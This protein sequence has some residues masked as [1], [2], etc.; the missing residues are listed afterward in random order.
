MSTGMIGVSFSK[1]VSK[2]RIHAW[3]GS[4]KTHFWTPSSNILTLHFYTFSVIYTFYFY[5]AF[6]ELTFYQKY[7][8]KCV[9]YSLFYQ[10][11]SP[12]RDVEHGAKGEGVSFK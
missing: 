7:S 8:I 6:E 5:I 3:D 1:S 9:L 4:C 11:I 10:L 2:V 12:L